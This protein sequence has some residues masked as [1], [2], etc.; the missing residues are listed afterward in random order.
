MGFQKTRHPWKDLVR[1]GMFLN[2]TAYC[3]RGCAPQRLAERNAPM[4]EQT[5]L[6]RRPRDRWIQI[7][8]SAGGPRRLRLLARVN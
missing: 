7:P 4:S 5:D 6:R 2:K 3:C 8:C 1:T